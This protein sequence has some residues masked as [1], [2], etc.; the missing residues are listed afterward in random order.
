[1]KR[2]EES[3]NV[4]RRDQEIDREWNSYKAGRDSAL[5]WARHWNTE[6]ASRSGAFFRTPVL[7]IDGDIAKLLLSG[8]RNE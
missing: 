2:V 3:G 6:K 4:I 8:T 5:E 1:M 7:L